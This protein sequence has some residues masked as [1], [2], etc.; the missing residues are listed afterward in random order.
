MLF[1]LVEQPIRI[2]EDTRSLE[3]TWSLCVCV[4]LNLLFALLFDQIIKCLCILWRSD[5]CVCV[6]DITA[7]SLNFSGADWHLNLNSHSNWVS[8][9]CKY[10][11]S[12][13]TSFSSEPSEEFVLFVD[14]N[15]QPEQQDKSMFYTNSVHVYLVC[16]NLGPRAVCLTPLVIQQYHVLSQEGSIGTQM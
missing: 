6:W 8:A 9:C 2:S 16:A 5:V 13:W 10:L 1:S 11:F 15:K 4:V 12:H 14:I 3:L 7:D